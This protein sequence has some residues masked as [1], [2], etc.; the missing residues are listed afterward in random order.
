M[1]AVKKKVFG[2]ALLS[3]LVILTTSGFV[4]YRMYTK[5]HR[6]VE[7]AKAVT[8]SAVKLVSEYEANEPMANGQY[9]DK[10]L[11][12]DGEITEI[13]KN[14]I[15]ETVIAL[16]GTDMGTVRCTVEGSAPAEITTGNK[17]LLK[18]ICTGYLMDVIMV[19]CVLE[20]R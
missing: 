15:G 18:G 11:E 9:L 3:A 10:V 12:V 16:K 20:K 1:T 17:A 8:V 6:N 7:Q 14:Q 5:P 19:R 2:W 13:S 4:A